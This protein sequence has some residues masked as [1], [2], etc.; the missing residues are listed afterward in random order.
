M[1]TWPHPAVCAIIEESLSAELEHGIEIGRYNSRGI[2]MKNLAAGD[3]LEW[4]LA[5]QYGG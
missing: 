3:V 1:G 4:H 5:E 2:G